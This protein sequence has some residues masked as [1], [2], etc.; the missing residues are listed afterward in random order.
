MNIP[1][2]KRGSGLG[3]DLFLVFVLI[4]AVATTARAADEDALVTLWK[5]HMAAPDDHQTVIKAC[6]MFSSSHSNDPLLPVARG[7]EAWHI[8][9]DG[10]RQEAFTMWEADLRL[11]PSPLNDCARRLAAGWMTRA[12]RETVAAALQAYYRKEVAYPKELAQIAAHPRLKNEPNIPDKDRFGKPWV[13]SL[14]GFDKVKGFDGQKYS[15]QSV[16]LGDI[17]A[18]KTAEKLPYAANILAVPLRVISMPDSTLAVSFNRG[19]TSALS[20]IGPGSGDLHLAFIGS[21]LIVVCDHTH[22]KILPRP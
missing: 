15:L 2:R 9:R 1:T 3:S 20:M 17:S 8:L 6:Q 19:T 18:L 12:D 14:T 13:Y 21:K 4:L 22:W 16:V 11:P 5:Q 10:R 7:I